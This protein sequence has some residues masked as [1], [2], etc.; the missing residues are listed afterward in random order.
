[1]KT[2]PTTRILDNLRLSFQ[3]A[4]LRCADI[5]ALL[6]ALLVAIYPKYT[7]FSLSHLYRTMISPHRFSLALALLGYIV[8][9]SLFRLYQYAWRFA[10]LDVLGGVIAANTLGIILFVLLQRILD[11]PPRYPPVVIIDFWLMGI[12]LIG[13]TR[14]SLRLANLG[15][16]YGRRALQIFQRDGT[17][18]RV[19]ILGGGPGSVRVLT[20]LHEEAPH[21][22]EIIGILSEHPEMQ[23]IYLRGT[24]VIGTVPAPV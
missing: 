10:S 1:M 4:I 16:N 24:R 19:V 6:F 8:A 22:Y 18:K 11:E 3:A 2:Q 14:I 13:G 23:G 9:F 17:Q 15:R 5:F 7:P 12:V 21:T 20:A